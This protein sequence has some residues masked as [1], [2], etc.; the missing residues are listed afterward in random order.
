MASVKWKETS[1]GSA[2]SKEKK[3]KESAFEEITEIE[4]EKKRTSWRDY[5][6]QP[7]IIVKIRGKSFREKSHQKKCG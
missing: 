5:W 6:L 4:E 2:Q 7:E 1:Q 3:K